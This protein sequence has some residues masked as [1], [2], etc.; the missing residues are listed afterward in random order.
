MF[1]S[2][3][4]TCIL[5]MHDSSPKPY[6]DQSH[7]GGMVSTPSSHGVNRLYASGTVNTSIPR[8]YAWLASCMNVHLVKENTI[9]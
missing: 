5:P 4:T 9:S 8:L 6:P 1:R 7:K 3:Y 2:L